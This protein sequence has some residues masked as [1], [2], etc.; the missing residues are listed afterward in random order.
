MIKPEEIELKKPV[1]YQ[2]KYMRTP[3]YGIITGVEGLPVHVHVLFAG[4]QTAKSCC[5]EDL[6]WPITFFPS[7]RS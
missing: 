7:Q 1:F 4:D 2:Q 6:F 5:L 3:E